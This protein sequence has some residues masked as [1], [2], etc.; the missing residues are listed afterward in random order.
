MAKK[1]KINVEWAIQVRDLGSRKV[2]NPK[3]CGVEGGGLA[4]RVEGAW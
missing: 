1:I 4:D 3:K 2:E